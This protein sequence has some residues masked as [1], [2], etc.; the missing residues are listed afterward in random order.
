[1]PLH[2]GS[3]KKVI[4]EN[5]REM[6]R[7]GHPEAQAVAAAMHVAYDNP[8]KKKGHAQ[9]LGKAAKYLNHQK[10]PKP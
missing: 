1:M 4:G 10:E 3:S 6:R 9:N 5:I 7:A 8:K 2:K